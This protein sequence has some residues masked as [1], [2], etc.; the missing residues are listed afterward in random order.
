MGKKCFSLFLLK[1][2]L[3]GQPDFLCLEEIIPS[4][5][6]F[7]KHGVRHIQLHLFGFYEGKPPFVGEQL[8][9][10]QIELKVRFTS[11]NG[12]DHICG[13]SG[14]SDPSHSP[15]LPL[16]PQTFA[17]PPDNCRLQLKHQDLPPHSSSL[18][19]DFDSSLNNE[20][21]KSFKILSATYAD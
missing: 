20:N 3:L 6:C 11:L 13:W 18:R 7:H 9:S 8:P 19:Q 1:S 12:G 4:R 5:T 10:R 2:S 21:L 16:T 17:L 14:F 15:S